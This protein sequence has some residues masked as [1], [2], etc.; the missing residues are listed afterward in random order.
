MKAVTICQGRLGEAEVIRRPDA[1]ELFE[2]RPL[3]NANGTQGCYPQ[4]C[5]LGD[6]AGQYDREECSAW[7]DWV[8]T[9]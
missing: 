5:S 6:T 3:P 9:G 7:E 2:Q 1:G 8:G 4:S